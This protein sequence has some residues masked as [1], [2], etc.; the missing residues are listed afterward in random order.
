MVKIH[1]IVDENRDFS[2]ASFKVLERFKLWDRRFPFLSIPAC[3][4]LFFIGFCYL[5][6]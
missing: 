4:F 1:K 6:F 3:S 5:V 2:L